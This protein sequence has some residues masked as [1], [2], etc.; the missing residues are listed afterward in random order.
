[1]STK[2]TPVVGAM[3][4]PQR[5]AVSRGRRNV[6]SRNPLCREV[7]NTPLSWVQSQNRPGAAHLIDLSDVYLASTTKPTRGEARSAPNK[8][9]GRAPNRES[10]PARRRASDAGL[11]RPVHQPAWPV[12]SSPAFARLRSSRRLSHGSQI[13][14]SVA[15]LAMASRYR[16]IQRSTRCHT[17]FT[18]SIHDSA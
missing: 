11:A 10:Q 6:S 4:V 16:D 12:R 14:A 13:P 17:F 8:R 5:N 2:E 9:T 7:V 3:A 18:G 15:D 1:V